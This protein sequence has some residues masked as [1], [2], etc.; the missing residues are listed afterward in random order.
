MMHSVTALGLILQMMAELGCLELVLA[1]LLLPFVNI[2]CQC[3]EMVQFILKHPSCISF[4]MTKSLKATKSNS[5][6]TLHIQKNN[7][8][9]IYACVLVFSYTPHLSLE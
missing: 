2:F 6:L 9:Q 5:F 3:R 7:D 8:Q 4:V 1:A